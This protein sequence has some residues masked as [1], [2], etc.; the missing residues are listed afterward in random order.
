MIFFT[1][2]KMHLIIDIMKNE[3]DRRKLIR[4]I[5]SVSRNLWRNIENWHNK[6]VSDDTM[7]KLKNIPR[8]LIHVYGIVLWYCN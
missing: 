6:Y 7:Q 2:L 5:R 3:G 1:K 8:I 4:C